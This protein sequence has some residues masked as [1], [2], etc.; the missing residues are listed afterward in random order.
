MLTRHG[1]VPATEGETRR[2]GTWC[3]ASL[4]PRQIHQNPIRL[5]ELCNTASCRVTGTR[6]TRAPTQRRQGTRH[7]IT[8]VTVNSVSSARGVTPHGDRGR[9]LCA[10]DSGSAQMISC[11]PPPRHTTAGLAS[12]PP[13]APSITPPIGTDAPR[14]M[15]LPSG[16]G[17]HCERQEVPGCRQGSTTRSQRLA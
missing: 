11:H 10:A 14:T 12:P 4:R 15:A 9:N 5:R 8:V 7:G 1:A 2:N 16:L 3:N 6:A 13:K 17:M